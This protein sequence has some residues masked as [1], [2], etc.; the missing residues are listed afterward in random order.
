[1]GIG[2]ALAFVAIGAIMAFAFH[3]HLSGVDIHA[4]GW[5]LILVG[6]AM[7]LIT[8]LYTRPRRR[9]QTVQ[10]VEGQPGA[11]VSEVEEP[12]IVQRPVNPNAPVQQQSVDPAVGQRRGD[13][14]PQ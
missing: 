5:I 13:V 1:M 10:V 4:V 14:P 11:Y 6:I 12:P 3:F 2:T 8:L 9:R 7:L